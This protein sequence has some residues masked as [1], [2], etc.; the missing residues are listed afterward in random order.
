LAEQ[1]AN[2]IRT[3]AVAATGNAHVDAVGAAILAAGTRWT[4]P[5]AE[6]GKVLLQCISTGAQIVLHGT[7]TN[8][9]VGYAPDGGVVDWNGVPNASVFTGM[10]NITGAATNFAAGV[11]ATVDIAE[12]EDAMMFGVGSNVPGWRYAAMAGKCIEPVDLSDVARDIGADA[13]LVGIPS[14]LAT[15]GNWL[16]SVAGSTSIGSCVR[17]GNSFDQMIVLT[18]F[19]WLA[20]TAA[21]DRVL[22]RVGDVE[23]MVP[24]QMHVLT[25]AA[26]QYV[27]ATKYIR[28]W[29]ANVSHGTRLFSATPLSEQAWFGFQYDATNRNQF[30]LWSKTET[31]V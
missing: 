16:S 21:G 19:V 25:T 6:A 13:L 27:G 9:Q 5:L 28:Q 17:T 26:A 12:Y 10:R 3:I 14:A 15:A 22:A 30:A 1:S 31:T 7:A 18:G 11:T 20:G 24:Y 2:V 8:I 29:R 4:R 23:R